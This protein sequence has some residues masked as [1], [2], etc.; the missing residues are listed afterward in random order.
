MRHSLWTDNP[1]NMKKIITVD[2]FVECWKAFVKKEKENIIKNYDN[3]TDRTCAVIGLKGS[4]DTG[5]PLGDF[6]KEHFNDN[7]SYRKE[8]GLVDLSIFKKDD[9]IKQIWD[10]HVPEKAGQ[11]DLELFPRYYHVLIEHEN[12]IEKTFEEMCKLTYFNGHLKV[13]ITYIWDSS[14]SGD[15]WDYAHE[16]LEKNFEIIIQQA[17]KQYPENCDTNYL[18]ITCQ[19]IDNKLIS[20]FSCFN[21]I[22][23][24]EQKYITVSTTTIWDKHE[25]SY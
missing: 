15:N 8:D 11:R 25:V 7:Y 9:C 5:S 2:T 19:R 24:I 18:L 21:T 17:N 6:I 22:S 16:R 23:M 14:K 3:R 10:M 4:C 13:L 12:V 1:T 20:R